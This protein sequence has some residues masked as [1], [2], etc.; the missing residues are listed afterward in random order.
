[1]RIQ[2]LS[3]ADFSLLGG[4]A[5]LSSQHL[6]DTQGQHLLRAFEPA[7]L[8]RAEPFAGIGEVEG[9]HAHAYRRSLRKF[10]SRRQKFNDILRRHSE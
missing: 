1:M 5:L 4:L 7:Q 2:A 3:Y 6:L 9:E 10:L 8:E